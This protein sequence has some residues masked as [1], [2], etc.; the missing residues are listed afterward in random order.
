MV[1]GDA[2]GRAFDLNRE[3]TILGRSKD[4]EIVLPVDTVSKRHAE[5]RKQANGFVLV[6]LKSRNRTQVNGVNLRAETPTQLRDGD[7]IT[8]CE[9]SFVF[10]NPVVTMQDDDEGS[11]TILGQIEVKSSLH[12]KGTAKAED[13]LPAILEISAAIGKT[14]SLREILE[15]TLASLFTI[16]PQAERGFVLLKEGELGSLVPHAILYRDEEKSR[17]TLS[18]TVFTHVMDEGRAILSTN[19]PDDSRFHS[20]KSLHD[21][22]IRTM[23]CVPLLN[24]EREPV[25]MIQIDT[26]NQKSKFVQDDLDLLVAVAGPIGLALENS[27]LHGELLRLSVMEAGLQHAHEVQI[28]LL[29]ENR[30]DEPGYEFWDAY[31]PAQSVGGDYFDYL[32]LPARTDGEKVW[33]ITLGDVSGKGMPAALLMAK[34]SSEVR[35]TLLTEPDPAN[36]VQKLNRQLLDARFPE[37]FITFVLVLLDTTRHTLTVV[38]AG[39][40]DPLI[41]RADGTAEEI[42]VSVAGPPL[43]VEENTVYRVETTTLAPGDVV[44]LYTDGVSE[45]M[46]SH[47]HIFRFDRLSETVLAAGNGPEAVGEAIVKAVRMHSAG[48]D[49]SDDIGLVCFGRV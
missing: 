42:G 27:R 18:Q 1:A 30:P 36:A 11:S 17:L 44:I 8:I 32:P 2:P 12:A 20:S 4:N 19:V 6:D 41:R 46:D 24:Q 3:R 13:K 7:Q 9:F 10:H 47:E 33:A 31:E 21:A 26:R 48:C 29:P 34:L 35:M 23:M 25:G 40:M 39:H 45:A 28:A 14:L 37:R 5:I 43:A 38:N 15:K 22:E 49:Q 16:F